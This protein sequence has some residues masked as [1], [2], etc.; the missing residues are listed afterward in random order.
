MQ[1]IAKNPCVADFHVHVNENREIQIWDNDVETLFC[2]RVEVKRV[3][4]ISHRT[5]NKN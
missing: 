2:V 1:I 3:L 5:K 4:E